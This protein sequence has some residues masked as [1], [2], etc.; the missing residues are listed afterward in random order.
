[1]SVAELRLELKPIAQ[2]EAR[3]YDE[4]ERAAAAFI[5]KQVKGLESDGGNYARRA[6]I[7][8]ASCKR[9]SRCARRRGTSNARKSLSKIAG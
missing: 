5:L 3:D 9:R 6:G 2:G 7:C 4:K 1:M 8:A